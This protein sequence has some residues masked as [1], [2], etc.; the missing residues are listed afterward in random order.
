MKDDPYFAPPVVCEF[1]LVVLF[2]CVALLAWWALPDLL[3]WIF[4]TGVV[5]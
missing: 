5:H 1:G 2:I 3:A 4:N